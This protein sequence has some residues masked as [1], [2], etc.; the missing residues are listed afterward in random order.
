MLFMLLRNAL[1]ITGCTVVTWAAPLDP[2][3]DF[4]G[5]NPNGVWSYGHTAALGSTFNLFNNFFTT[6]D[7]EARSQMAAWRE[8]AVDDF[9][10]VYQTFTP[11]TLLLHPGAAGQYSVLRFTAP[12]SGLYEFSGIFSGFGQTTTDVHVLLNGSSLFD[13]T[14]NGLGSTQA[15]SGLQSLGAGSILDFVVG[16][17][18]NGNGQD[19]TGLSLQFEAVPEAAPEPGTVGL[20]TA[21]LIGVLFSARFRKR[22]Q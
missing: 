5:S 10:G 4:A 1:L 16:T 21:G 9:L 14:I 20:I 22:M 18:A 7:P 6:P 2:Y 12:L 13:S 8:S 15:F 17:G 3:S 11:G 19:S